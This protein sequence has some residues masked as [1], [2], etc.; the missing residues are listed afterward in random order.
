MKNIVIIGNYNSD[1]EISYWCNYF[2]KRGYKVIDYPKYPDNNMSPNSYQNFYANIKDANILFIINNKKNEIEGYVDTVTFSEIVYAV[3]KNLNHKK[4][5]DIYILKLPNKSLY[6]Y[7]EILS[8]I[9]KGQIKLFKENF[10]VDLIY[11]LTEYEIFDKQEA[12]DKELFLEYMRFYRDSPPSPKVSHLLTQENKFAHF[13]ASAFVVNKD[14]TKLLVVYSNSFNGWTYP[15][16]HANGEEDL[17]SVAIDEVEKVTGQRAVILDNSIFSI[18][19][20]PISGH[21]VNGEYIPTHIHLDVVFLLELDDTK[22]LTFDEDVIKN[23]KWIPLEKFFNKNTVDF[24]KPIHSKLLKK[25]LENI[26]S[27]QN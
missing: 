26:D 25:F 4:K 27:Y 10:K 15:S 17:L 18:Q 24:L 9:N 16:K 22:P 8:F 13:C 5:I 2:N 20:I 23:V 19:T 1:K 11:E 12:K 6:Y 14:K 21:T 7:A 3:M